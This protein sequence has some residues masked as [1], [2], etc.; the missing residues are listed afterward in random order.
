MAQETLKDYKS[1]GTRIRKRREE[2]GLDI[3]DIAHRIQ[4]SQQNIEALESDRF[5]QFPAKVYARGFFE[6]I[7]VALQFED[8]DRMLKEFD[9]E[10][11]VQ[12]FR[13]ER[14]RGL[15]S[16]RGTEPL[17]TPGR[18]WGGIGG[19][20]AVAFAV[21]FGSQLPNLVGAPRLSIKTPPEQSLTESRILLV[22]GNAERESTLTVNGRDIPVNAD[23]SFKSTIEL[24]PEL[25]RLE[26]VSR[27]KFNRE[28][29]DV[30]YV[31][32]SESPPHAEER[33]IP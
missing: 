24:I 18:I 8:R 22:S 11:E 27:G 19:V 12:M 9:S 13:R 23:G 26:F 14:V 28:Q 2:L 10:W 29:R 15:P 32:V 33:N 17:L 4:T 25:N 31:Y 5:D 3:R 30:R 16:N 7:A 1:L 20:A 21:L 6:K